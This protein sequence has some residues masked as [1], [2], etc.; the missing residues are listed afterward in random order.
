MFSQHIKSYY[1]LTKPGIIYGNDI[2]AVAGFM[3]ASKGRFD[4]LIFLSMLIGTSLVIGSACTVNN[5]LDKDIDRHMERTKKRALVVGK[6]SDTNALVFATILGLAGFT[7]LYFG[8]NLLTVIAGL[9]GY[10]FYVVI[11]GYAKRQTVHGTVIGSISGAIPP[12]GGYLAA[13]NQFDTGAILLFLVLA[14]WQMPH[15]YAIGLFRLEDYKAAGIPILPVVKGIWQTKLQIVLYVLGFCMT[16]F[17][18]YIYQYTG[19]IYLVILGLFNLVWVW[20]SIQGFYTNDSAVWAK[21]MFGWSL[22][23]LLVFCILISLDVYL[24]RHF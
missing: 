3:L 21:K 10:F 2:A 15:F 4:I 24:P 12:V 8:T 6:I 19:L 18:L 9:I 11:Y 1:R 20:R 23:V 7:I 5:F 17:L 14:F 22:V 16:S 13:S